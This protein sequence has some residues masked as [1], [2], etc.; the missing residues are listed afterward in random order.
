MVSLELDDDEKLDAIMPMPMP[1]VPDYPPGTQLCLT[2]TTLD[3]FGLAADCS[4]GDFLEFRCLAEVTFVS[5]TDG[6]GGK[7]CR[8]ELQIIAIDEDDDDE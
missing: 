7:D 5:N 8:V 2:K 6:P 3:K 4:K 1:S